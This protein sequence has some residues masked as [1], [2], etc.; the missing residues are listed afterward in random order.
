MSSTS[1]TATVVQATFAALQ[2]AGRPA[3]ASWGI[4]ANGAPDQFAYHYGNALVG[5][6]TSLPSLETTMTDLVVRF[7]VEVV[8]AVTGARAEVTIGGLSARMNQALVVPAG[9]EL[10][11]RDIRDGTRGY[12]SVFG[13]FHGANTFLGSVSPDRTL[14]F[15]F[16][17]TPGSTLSCGGDRLDTSGR[18][19]AF[20]VFDPP[21]GPLLAEGELGVL[22]GENR[23]LFEDRASELFEDDYVMTD[24]T[25][26]VGA[27]LEGR[28]PRRLDKG[29]ILS[30][31]LPIGAVEV[32]GGKELL[33]L[34]R[35]RGLSAGYPVVGVICTASMNVLSQARPGTSVRFVPLTI[36][37]ARRLR[38]REAEVIE[39]VRERMTTIIDSLRVTRPGGPRERE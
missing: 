29:E 20:P 21:R 16:D 36:A 18:R 9:W 11:V 39:S 4:A 2:D 35:G 12:V 32:A 34:N 23:D 19:Y 22:P 28:V 8:V 33:V 13:G 24:R 10:T 6:P 31:A 38:L 26:A 3:G 15:G 14:G 1:G 25:D 17:L 30:R 7:D 37:D 27:R 5:N